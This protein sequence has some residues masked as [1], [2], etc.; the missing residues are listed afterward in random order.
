ML[1]AYES[2]LKCND[3]QEI[4]CDISYL[5]SGCNI[6]MTNNA[7][8]FSSLD[9]LFQTNVTLGNNVQVI[10]LGKSNFGILTKHGQKNIMPVLIMSKL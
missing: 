7:N 6:H 2:P 4:P 1:L 10:V 5:D 3:V 9:K 8:I